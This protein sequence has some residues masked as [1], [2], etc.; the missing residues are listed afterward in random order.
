MKQQVRVI[1]TQRDYA[2]SLARLSALMDQK[3][4]H[5]S[6]QESELE[7]L[8]LVIEAY[9]RGKVSPAIL[10]PVEAIRF[11]MDQQKLAPKDLVPL[12]GSISKVSE[13][14]ARKRQLS[15]A[16]IR[17]LHKGLG[18]PAEVLISASAESNLDIS[19]QP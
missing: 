14:L 8:A 16:M 12:L 17:A 6:N 13:I 7:L 10:D 4:A 2:A 19:V 15:L 5:G 1:K 18:I 11:R 9:E 3:F